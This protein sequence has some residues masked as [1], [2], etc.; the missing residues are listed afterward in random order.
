MAVGDRSGILQSD[1]EEGFQFVV[2][3]AGDNVLDK[4]VEIEIDEEIRLRGRSRPL[5]IFAAAKEN[6]LKCHGLP[7]QD[8]LLQ[9]K[10]VSRGK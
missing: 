3:L 10:P 1:V 2:A 6:A 5:P 7:V 8:C 9:R 4:L